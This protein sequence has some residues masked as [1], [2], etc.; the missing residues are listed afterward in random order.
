MSMRKTTLPPRATFAFCSHGEK[1]PPQDGL[2]GI[3][4]RVPRLSKLLRSNKNSCEQLQVSE[5]AQRES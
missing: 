5:S 2:P 3:V 1:L 4:Q